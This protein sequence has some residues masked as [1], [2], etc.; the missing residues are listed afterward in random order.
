MTPEAIASM[1]FMLEQMALMPDGS[2]RKVE[3]SRRHEAGLT[4]LWEVNSILPNVGLSHKTMTMTHSE[5][6]LNISQKLGHSDT[7]DGVMTP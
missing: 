1:A 6:I 5:K 3:S 7:S 2:A 4:L